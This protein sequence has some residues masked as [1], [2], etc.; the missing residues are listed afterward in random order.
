VFVCVYVCVCVCVGMC[1]CVGVREKRV[2]VCM[3]VYVYTY[4]YI[5]K[6][7]YIFIHIYIC[8]YVYRCIHWR[9]LSQLHRAF[10]L[11]R[12]HVTLPLQ[13]ERIL[14]EQIHHEPILH[15]L[16]FT[17]FRTNPSRTTHRFCRVA[18]THARILQNVTESQTQLCRRYSKEPYRHSKEPDIPSKE[19]YVYLKE[20]CIHSKEPYIH[21]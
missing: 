9:G 14:Y 2:R 1:V 3:L 12:L 20:P 15:A 8:M 7:L 13:A 6:Y 5:Y 21:Q 11:E 16:R 18:C 17:N 19:P 4:I 10:Q